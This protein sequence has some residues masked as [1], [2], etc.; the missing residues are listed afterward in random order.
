MSYPNSPGFKTD[1][2]SREAAGKMRRPA[3][4]LRDRV[5]DLLSQGYRLTADEI[6]DVLHES[7]LSIRPRVSELHR[8][9]LIQRSSVRRTNASG[10]QAHVWAAAARR[11]A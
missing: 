9:G 6:A 7:I 4:T 3:L 11:P 5:L 8:K 2:T 1:G 10:M